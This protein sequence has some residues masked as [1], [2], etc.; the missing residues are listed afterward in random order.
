MLRYT[1]RT[2]HAHPSAFPAAG[3][4]LSLSHLN[5][6]SGVSTAG[7]CCMSTVDLELC[8]HADVMRSCDRSE[9]D[10]KLLHYAAAIAGP[11]PRVEHEKVADGR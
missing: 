10:C 11:S 5:G 6:A 9:I 4:R 2:D 3:K 1:E 8:W 7:D